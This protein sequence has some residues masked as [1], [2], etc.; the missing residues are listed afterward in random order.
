[1]L[2]QKGAV[3]ARVLAAVLSLWMLVAAAGIYPD[4]LSYFNE[5]ACLVRDP[6]RIGFD[7]GTKCGP[8]WLD[9]SNVDWGQSLKQLQSWMDE[10]A[11]GRTIH[12]AYFGSFPPEA[13]GIPY[14]KTSFTKLLEAP[15]PGLYAVSAHW[16]ARLPALGASQWLRNTAPAAVI[17]HSLYVY[18]IPG[19]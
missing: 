8:L 9:D 13:Y 17:G 3:W 15:A 18:D 5:A 4:H 16:V 10:H 11:R 7:G 14:E 6:S 19:K 1:M 2:I 12:L